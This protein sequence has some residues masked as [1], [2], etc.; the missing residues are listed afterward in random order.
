VDEQLARIRRAYDRDPER[1]WARLETG[2]QNRLE[3]LITSHALERDLPAPAHLGPVLDAGGGPG[4]Y[5]ILLAER[6]YRVTLLDLSPGLLALA[7]QRIE[8]AGQEIMRQV[9]AVVEGTFTDLSAFPDSSFGAVLCLGAA[10]SHVVDPAQRRQAVAELRRVAQP[11]ALLFINVLNYVGAFRAVVQWWPDASTIELFHRLSREQVLDI[12][13]DAAPAYLY[14]PEE[15]RGM[16]AE[17]GLTVERLYGAEGIGAHLQED[18][19]LAVMDDP[20]VWPA[21]REIL[22]STADHPSVVGVSRSLLAVARR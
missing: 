13:D 2:A 5:T 8:Q 18:H 15:F 21:W 3:L 14:Y 16:L 1:E 4:R 17:A 6:G 12:G 9:E 20:E 11:G 10:L 22:L 7:R 19:L